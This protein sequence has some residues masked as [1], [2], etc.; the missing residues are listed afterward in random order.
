MKMFFN[1]HIFICILSFKFRVLV[2]SVL[3]P[4]PPPPQC[5]RKTKTLKHIF[6][7]L[8]EYNLDMII[9]FPHASF[10]N[11]LISPDTLINIIYVSDQKSL[12]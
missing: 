4:H 6:W 8:K 10:N 7:N 5:H 2:H 12:L 9:Y 1:M 11:S 3:A